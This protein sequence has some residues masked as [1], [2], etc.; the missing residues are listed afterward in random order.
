MS[1]TYLFIND[2]NFKNGNLTGAHRR[3]LELVR[4]IAKAN[5]RIIIV[6]SEIPQLEDLKQIIVYKTSKCKLNLPAHV[7]GMI[8][9]YNILKKIKK[10]IY[11][12]YAVSF[13]AANTICYWA[14]GYKNIIT[15]FREDMIGY[16]QVL[17][18]SSIKIAY[19]RIQEYIAV[20]V[21]D[22]IIVQCRN[23]RDNLV[24]RNKRYYNHIEN[25]IFVQ[26][27]NANASWMNTDI[28][29]CLKKEDDTIRIL[30]IGDFSN[31]RKGHKQLLLAFV[32]LL[33]EFK[34]LELY[35]AGGGLQFQEYKELYRQYPE[36]K[37]LG[38]VRNMQKYLSMCDFE[39]VPSLIDSCP[40]TILEGINAGIAVYGSDRGGIPDLLVK[41]EY[42]FKPNEKDI[43]LFLKDVIM[44]KRYLKD[45]D[46]QKM[47]KKELTFNWSDRIINIIEC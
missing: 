20:G 25:K 40:N 11:Y 13:S 17:N 7:K 38:R 36:I 6:A 33:D 37:F 35:V 12:D 44:E 32:R 22:K 4:G 39:I 34:N 31:D 24:K 26:I 15:L 5:N 43:F 27:N 21:S 47:R 29:S 1:K 9:L 16:L 28:V 3:F 2:S 14:C 23:D 30:F 41:D 42:M 10:N 46:M 19:A 45:K 18:I 8:E